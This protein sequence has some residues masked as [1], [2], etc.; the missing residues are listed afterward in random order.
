MILE[1]IADI[2]RRRCRSTAEYLLN[3][4]GMLSGL[5]FTDDKIGIPVLSAVD[6]PELP[7]DT[8]AFSKALYST[9][10]GKL[11]H[12][13]ECDQAF[14]RILHQPRKY[15]ELLKR[16]RYVS[17]PDFSQKIGMPEF[18]R[19]QNSW[20][21]K[22]LTAYW[23]SEGIPVIPNVSWSDPDS[24][25]YAFK[26][27]PKH[28]VIAINFVGVRSCHWSM[29]LWRKGYEEALRRLEPKLI[30]RYGDRMPGENEACSVYFEN[31]NYKR[32]RDGR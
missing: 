11:V 8:L 19:F 3:K 31:E 18:V 2:K 12:F 6:L 20:W 30:I 17:G 28:S 16:F 22:A 10:T 9:E 25:E 23:Q 1:E 29:Y 32:L 4:F 21:N 14:A 7:S 13:Y 24:Y 15:M 27:L 26:G 5:E